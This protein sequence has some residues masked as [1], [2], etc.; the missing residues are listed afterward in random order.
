MRIQPGGPAGKY[1]AAL[2]SSLAKIMASRR[3]PNP[4]RVRLQMSKTREMQVDITKM[5]GRSGA[6]SRLFALSVGNLSCAGKGLLIERTNSLRRVI[7]QQRNPLQKDTY[8][9]TSLYK[10]PSKSK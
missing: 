6:F 10:Y 9:K 2:G 1:T 5:T 4:S 7:S 3:W 8:V